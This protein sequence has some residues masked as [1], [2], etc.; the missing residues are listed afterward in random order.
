M[1]KLIII[2]NLTHDPDL[3]MTNN[4]IPVC[5]FSVAVNRQRKVEGQ[6]DVDYFRVTTWRNIAESCYAYLKKGRKVACTGRVWLHT[7]ERDGRT[8][9]S[10]EMEADEVEF[11]SPKPAA[12]ADE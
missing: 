6:P 12:E 5:S 9:A 8:Y 3:R 2:G 4:N 1:N 11:V 10:L 7:Y